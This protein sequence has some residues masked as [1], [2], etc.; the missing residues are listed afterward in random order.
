MVPWTEPR[1]SELRNTPTP[2]HGLHFYFANQMLDSL[3]PG[4]PGCEPVPKPLSAVLLPPKRG[5]YQG[6]CQG[7]SV[8]DYLTEPAP[9]PGC[10]TTSPSQPHSVRRSPPTHIARQC[11]SL[12]VLCGLPAFLCLLY[13]PTTLQCRGELGVSLCHLISTWPTMDTR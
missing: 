5:M 10:S 12:Q 4:D 3:L 9:T 11:T 8:P 2:P 6:P 7:S 13:L 1:T